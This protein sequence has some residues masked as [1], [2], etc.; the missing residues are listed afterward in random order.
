MRQITALI[1][2]VELRAATGTYP[3]P[4]FILHFPHLQVIILAGLGDLPG[5]VT[6]TYIPGQSEPL[7]IIP[8]SVRSCYMSPFT[9]TVV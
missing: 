2:A 5:S 7:V 1:T 6:Q 9:V 4:R 3:P 8:S